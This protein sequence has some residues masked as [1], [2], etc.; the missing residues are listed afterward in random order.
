[1]CKKLDAD[2]KT[3]SVVV[4]GDKGRSQMRRTVG[5]KIKV[6]RGRSREKGMSTGM[7]TNTNLSASLLRSPQPR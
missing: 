7:H 1:M 4:V 3:S 5:E 6:R 2:G